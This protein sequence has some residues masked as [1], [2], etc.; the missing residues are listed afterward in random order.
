LVLQLLQQLALNP[1]IASFT[2]VIGFKSTQN[3]W[4]T[5]SFGKHLYGWNQSQI[6]KLFRCGS[7]SH[8]V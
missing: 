1:R 6:S 2:I 8:R 3:S 7:S 4:P 5:Q